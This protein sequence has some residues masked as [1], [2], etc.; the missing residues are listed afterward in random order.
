MSH[1]HSIISTL[2]L[3]DNKIKDFQILKIN[4]VFHFKIPTF[5]FF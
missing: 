3:P 1:E 4:G 5:P 2:N